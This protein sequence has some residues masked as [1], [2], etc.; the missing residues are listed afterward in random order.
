MLPLLLRLSP[1]AG[2]PAASAQPAA[3]ACLAVLLAGMML[4]S[5]HQLQAMVLHLDLH[6]DLD[7]DL[8]PGTHIIRG[9]TAWRPGPA[10]LW[11]GAAIRARRCRWQARARPRSRLLPGGTWWTGIWMGGRIRI[12]IGTSTVAAATVAVTAASAMMR[13]MRTGRRTSGR[14]WPRARRRH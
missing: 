5:L 6:L 9:S 4:G 1:V 13:Q 2:A 14:R 11:G 12:R 3:A 10:Q 7:P 8:P